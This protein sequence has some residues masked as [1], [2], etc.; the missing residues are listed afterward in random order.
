MPRIALAVIVL[1]A[2]ICA[3][4]GLGAGSAVGDETPSAPQPSPGVPTAQQTREAL[5]SSSV[6]SLEQGAETDPQVAEELPHRDLGREEAL[7]LAEGVFGAELEG[8][9]GIYDELEPTR[10]LSDYAAVVPD[11]GLPEPAGQAGAE[12]QSNL[13]PGQSVLV[14]STLPLRTEDAEGEE[15]P[16]DLSLESQEGSGGELQP[17]NPLTELAIPGRLGEGISV[18]GVGIEL[19][20]AAQETAPTDVEESYAFYPNVAENTDL[21]VAPTATGAET[22]TDV[23]S[24]EAPQTTT[25]RLSL[26]SGATLESG[27]DGSAEVVQGGRRTMLIP[28][29]SA[30]D[31]AG[32]KVPVDMEV[33]GDA[34]KVAISP[35]ASTEF[36][37]M[38]DP[39]YIVESWCWSGCGAGR[40]GWSPSST[41]AS[42]QPVWGAQWDPAHYAGLDLTA[43]YPGPA[44]SGT[45]ADWAYWVP[46]YSQD[47]TKYATPPTTY[48]AYWMAEGVLFLPFGNYSNYPVMVVG[49]IEPATGWA[50]GDWSHYGGQGEKADWGNV[51]LPNLSSNPM[52][53]KGADEDL[54]TYEY[55]AQAKYRDTFVA[56]STIEVVDVDAPRLEPLQAP[57]GWVT[58]A[59]ASIG[60]GFEDTGLGVRSAGVKRA[61]EASLHPGWG[62]DFACSGTTASPC[63]R[64]VKSSETGARALSFVPSELPT[65]KDPLEVTVED[66]LREAGHTATGKVTVKVDNTPPELSL[67]GPLAER[68]PATAQSPLPHDPVAAYSFDEGQGAVAHDSSGHGHE[69][70]VENAQWT[71][72]RFGESLKFAEAW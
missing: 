67:S 42:Y 68:E 38:V 46:R 66:P 27:P 51:Y 71:S 1:I 34:L 25:Y 47:M 6:Q 2:V 65:G 29:P 50:P 30:T 64:V 15:A 12:A 58:G 45:H 56:G 5:E 43:G 57:G 19:A 48:V 9:G 59:S 61:G 18:G 36:P 53:V 60:Y 44:Y 16:V 49:L 41:N 70:T 37:V 40:F 20:G 28:P 10:F 35:A 21:V 3:G 31:A 23:R 69:G 39:N 52:A 72:G 14:E 13:P 55:E 33:E 24:A 26:P 11:S 22:M 62:A 17:R 63:P 4:I 8:P 32:N 54:V 7:E